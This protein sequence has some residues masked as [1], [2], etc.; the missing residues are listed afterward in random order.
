[1]RTHGECHLPLVSAPDQ[2][3]AEKVFD[4]VWRFDFT[5]P[6]F[7]LLDIGPGVDSHTLRS[8]MVDLKER[9]SKVAVRRGGQPFVFRSMARFDQQETTKF[10]LDGAPERSM[11]M[12]GY[13]PSKVRSRLF[14]ADYTR[15]AF[16]LGITPQ[17]FLQ[18][19]NPMYQ[20]GEEL[21]GRYVT[22]LPQP[23]EGHSRILLINNSS[24]SFTEGGANSLGIMHKA[25]IVNPT[26]AERRIVNST[27][28]VTEGEENSPEKLHEFVT[29]HKI[30]Q[31]VYG[32]VV[33][34]IESRSTFGTQSRSTMPG[35]KTCHFP[36]FG[37][38][39]F[40]AFIDSRN[41]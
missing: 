35:G 22:E 12:L 1:M 36:F 6:G 41:R 2:A 13:E 18:D 40:L 27:M 19:F 8:W 16:D 25:E 26:E 32:R 10:H 15:A 3:T 38:A 34:G 21:L 33:I 17:Q 37:A 31:K 4:L 20:R 7:C 29:T 9:L 24:L 39:S 14:L 28:L 5:M 30:S 23:V 11:L